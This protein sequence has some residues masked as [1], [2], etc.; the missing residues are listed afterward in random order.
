[1]ALLSKEAYEGKRKYAENKAHDNINIATEHGATEEQ[2]RA[3]ARLCAD[4]HFL[5]SNHEKIFNDNTAE[6]RE[7][8]SMLVD[9]GSLNNINV[10]LSN[11]GLEQINALHEFDG[12]PT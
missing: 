1:M 6:A 3:I 5:H 9:D 2:A 4:R 11:A 12:V 10:Y 7:A 8:C